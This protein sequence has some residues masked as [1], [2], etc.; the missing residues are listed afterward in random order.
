MKK[1]Y[2]NKIPFLEIRWL[3]LDLRRWYYVRISGYLCPW[4][5]CE[6]EM[7]EIKLDY[8]EHGQKIEFKKIPFW[9]TILH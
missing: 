5:A 7:E 4:W 3:T 6:D 2:K 8:E 1:L 9:K